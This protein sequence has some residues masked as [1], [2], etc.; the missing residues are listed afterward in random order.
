R[1]EMTRGIHAVLQSYESVYHDVVRRAGKLTFSDVQRLLVPSENGPGVL[2]Q[3]PEDDR[4]LYIDFRLDAEIDHWLL[5]EF[6][7]TGFGLWSVL[8][9]LVEEALKH[10]TG[11]RSLFNVGDV[12]Q[13]SYAWRDG[14]PRLFREIFDHHNAVRP[15]TIQVEH[16]VQS[17]RSGP[18]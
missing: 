15:G 13:A 12:R 2:S 11:G 8:R 6:Q 5:D 10:P 16:L 14:H 17:W 4:R 7:C 9:N 1:L 3:D 18:A